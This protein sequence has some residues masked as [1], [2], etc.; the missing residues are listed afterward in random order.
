MWR[1]LGQA[2]GRDRV[3]ARELGDRPFVARDRLGAAR[4]LLAK[5]VAL[6]AGAGRR[7]GHGGE[8]RFDVG[9]RRPVRV[10]L[11]ERGPLARARADLVLQGGDAVGG[12]FGEEGLGLL[13]LGGEARPAGEA[14]LGLGDA[15]RADPFELAREGVP[16]VLL[17]R[18]AGVEVGPARAHLHRADA[19]DDDADRRVAR[20]GALAPL[21]EGLAVDDEVARGVQAERGRGGGERGAGLG[22]RL[23]RPAKALDLR[24]VDP[25]FGELRPELDHARFVLLGACEAG[26]GFVLAPGGFVEVRA[27]ACAQVLRVRPFERDVGRLGALRRLVLTRGNLRLGGGTR[28]Q[29]RSLFGEAPLEHGSPLRDLRALL[30]CALGEIHL[31]APP[32]DVGLVGVQPPRELL[33]PRDLRRRVR[34]AP[35]LRPHFR[36]DRPELA[37]ERRELVGGGV[38]VVA[39]GQRLGED[40]FGRGGARAG[41]GELAGLFPGRGRVVAV[42]LRLRPRDDSLAER[43]GGDLVHLAREHVAEA[44]ARVVV[45]VGLR[46]ED[47]VPLLHPEERPEPEELI[48][49]AP[50]LD[51]PRPEELAQHRLGVVV[52]PRPAAT[53]EARV[54]L[55]EEL[56]PRGPDRPARLEADLDARRIRRAVRAERLLVLRLPL[57]ALEE[58]VA[59]RRDQARLPRFVR[60]DD[61]VQVGGEVRELDVVEPLPSVDRERD[62][63]HRRSSTTKRWSRRSASSAAGVLEARRASTARPTKPSTASVRRSSSLGRSWSALASI[64]RCMSEPRAWARAR[65]RR[66]RAPSET[67]PAKVALTSVIEGWSIAPKKRS[68]SATASSLARSK[69]CSTQRVRATAI[70]STRGVAPGASISTTSA[71]PGLFSLKRVASGAPGYQ[72]RGSNESVPCQ[73]PRAR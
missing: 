27:S 2:G 43:P 12:C 53:F 3:I 72:T 38:G 11:A 40:G 59:E 26:G 30:S 19:V 24:F 6:A 21:G 44:R 29:R 37:P 10:R 65:S 9:E 13:E 56:L 69:R 70:S 32:G 64:R 52:R 25:R 61:E 42:P 63:P 35:L 7:V 48:D 28:L 47:R 34:D 36:V 17:A 55:R 58:R 60:A 23:A 16:R 50:S 57:V 5:G 41:E 15:R 4:D 68:T 33:R 1:E 8:A 18:A 67:W 45:H 54:G 62:E 49:L 73:S 51:R 39:F 14:I 20:P 66:A 31:R 46:R 71:F 22:E